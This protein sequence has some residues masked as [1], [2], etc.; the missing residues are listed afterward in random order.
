[1]ELDMDLME[2]MDEDQEGEFAEDDEDE[3]KSSKKNSKKFTGMHLQPE[4]FTG[5]SRTRSKDYSD[6]DAHCACNQTLEHCTRVAL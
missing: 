1:M 6:A 2:D 5:N 3:S 4:Q